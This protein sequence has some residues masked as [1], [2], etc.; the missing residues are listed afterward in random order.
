[1]FFPAPHFFNELIKLVE[2]DFC[3]F[4][5]KLV[6]QPFKTPAMFNFQLWNENYQISE[7]PQNPRMV[8]R[9][10]E[11]SVLDDTDLHHQ[12]PKALTSLTLTQLTLFAQRVNQAHP[13]ESVRSDA[14]LTGDTALKYVQE[15]LRG[16]VKLN[17]PRGRDSCHSVC[18][19]MHINT[20]VAV[21]AGVKIAYIS[22]LCI[23]RH[24]SQHTISSWIQQHV[25][26][27]G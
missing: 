23:T 10:H 24:V 9:G 14:L 15:C 19:P 17:I 6:T 2:Y 11:L 26:F 20:T 25:T 21:T 27:L 12:I 13:W 16:Y 18:F 1:M 5:L 4:Q 3:P 8:T 7:I 22:A